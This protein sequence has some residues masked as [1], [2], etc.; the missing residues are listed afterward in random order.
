MDE[1]VHSHVFEP[2]FTTKGPDLGT[3]LG[4]ATCYGVIKQH[5]GDIA[6]DSQIGSGTTVKIHL[7]RITEATAAIW[8]HDESP[9][10]PQGHEV[11]LLVEDEPSVRALA[12]RVLRQQ[13]YH[14]LEA[15]NGDEA[16]RVV[17]EHTAEP[18]ALLLTDMVMPQM[19]GQAL[20]EQLALLRPTIKVL[21]MS[22]YTD[23]VIVRQSQLISEAAFLPKPFSLEGLARK[24][25]EVLDA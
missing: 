4:L 3:G 5:G 12:A 15:A 21:F 17:R 7:P 16:L 1:H 6:I 18:I 13:G 23:G 9:K 19:G 22:G 14:V 20:A 8:Q 11:V 25:R 10:L 24:V 2:F